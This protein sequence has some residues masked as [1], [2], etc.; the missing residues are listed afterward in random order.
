M[1]FHLLISLQ[2]R[3]K[4]GLPILHGDFAITAISP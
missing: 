4:A 3:N 2:L 1:A